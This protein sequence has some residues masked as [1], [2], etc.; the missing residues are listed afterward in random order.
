MRDRWLGVHA[1]LLRRN[2]QD[3]EDKQSSSFRP[4][5]C[6]RCG[7]PTNALCTLAALE[8]NRDED[9]HHGE[10]TRNTITSCKE[11]NGDEEET[12]KEK[13]PRKIRSQLE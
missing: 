13:E 1:G 4:V 8:Q 2:T 6:H 11:D 10:K 7:G 3:G 9:L 12:G 5:E